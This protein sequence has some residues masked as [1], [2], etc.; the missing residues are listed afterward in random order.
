VVIAF[1]PAP[2][3]PSITLATPRGSGLIQT[4]R[5]RANNEGAPGARIVSQGIAQC[6]VLSA[7]YFPYDFVSSN[8]C[9]LLVVEKVKLQR[10]RFMRASVSKTENVEVLDGAL[11]MTQNAAA[12]VRRLRSRIGRSPWS[13]SSLKLSRSC[14]QLAT[15]WRRIEILYA[16]RSDRICLFRGIRT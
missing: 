8:R 11:S 10:P 5:A 14:N 15:F 6:A 2:P 4:L 7:S 16:S 9:F 13:F 1:F 3:L 12:R